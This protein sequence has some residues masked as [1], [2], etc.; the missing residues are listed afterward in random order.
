MELFSA[1]YGRKKHLRLSPISHVLS[2]LPSLPFISPLL[3]CDVPLSALLHVQVLV[4]VM[5]GTR[6]SEVRRKTDGGNEEENGKSS[7]RSEQKLYSLPLSC[8]LAM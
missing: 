6:G 3:Y 4:Y 7:G 5:K 8:D 2:S 1:L